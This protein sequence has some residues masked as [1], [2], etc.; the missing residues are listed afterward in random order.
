MRPVAET[1]TPLRDIDA[2]QRFFD[3]LQANMPSVAAGAAIGAAIGFV[4]G[5][6]LGLF[7]VDFITAPLLAVVGG[8][9]G[10]FIGLQQSGGAPA[11]DAAFSFADSL[12]PGAS[13]AI[14]P[15][16]TVLN[17]SPQPTS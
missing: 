6:P 11:V 3:V 12:L 15:L 16:A 9:V 8:L 7:V 10:G 1:E 2:Q 4:A 17:A 5:F 13:D 14:R